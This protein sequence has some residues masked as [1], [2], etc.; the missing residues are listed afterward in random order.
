MTPESLQTPPGFDPEAYLE[1]MSRA[2]DMPIDP[3]YRDNV[4]LHLEL[5][6]R[7]AGLVASFPLPDELEPAFV[8]DPRK[9]SR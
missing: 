4:K 8:F 3:A 7:M 9:L 1:L 6:A 2:L 5:T